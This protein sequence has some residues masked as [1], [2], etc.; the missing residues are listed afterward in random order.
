MN[1]KLYKAIMVRSQPR[2]YFL[3]NR[4]EEYRKVYNK[5]KVHVVT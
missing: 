1:K 4:Y 3:K 2:N 5:I